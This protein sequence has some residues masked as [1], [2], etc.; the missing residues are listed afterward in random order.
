MGWSERQVAM[1]GEMGVRVWQVPAGA[2]T[3]VAEV[4]HVEAVGDAENDSRPQHNARAEREPDSAR[5]DAPRTSAPAV[6]RTPPA[7]PGTPSTPS[8]PDTPAVVVPLRRELPRP[9]AGEGSDLQAV[10]AACTACPLSEDRTQPVFGIGHAQAH[11]MIVGEVPGEQEDRDNE[12]FVGKPGELLDNM[13]RALGLGRHDAGPEQQVFIT[14][15]VKCRPAANRGVD[16]QELAQCSAHLHQQI[17]QVRPRM[18]VALGRLAAQALLQSNEPLG[19]LRGRVHQVDG[20]AVVV[21]YPPSYLLRNPEDKARAWDDLCL[22]REH[23]AGMLQSSTGGS[24][25]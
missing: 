25:P 20:V 2:S 1:L 4:A 8:T 16:P 17:A 19:K 14:H 24:P 5:T 9:P 11:W 3:D 13:L 23:L 10:I 6:A 22:A 12:P 15:A 21:T 7:R 18:I